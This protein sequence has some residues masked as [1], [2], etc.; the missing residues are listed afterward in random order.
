MIIFGAVN[1]ASD[2]HFVKF[3]LSCLLDEKDGS[4]IFSV[5]ASRQY[6]AIPRPE[7]NPVMLDNFI[8]SLA[9]IDMPGLFIPRLCTR[10]ILL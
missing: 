4:Y 3:S 7:G 1:A 5:K 10:C 6:F 9:N 8:V 2:F